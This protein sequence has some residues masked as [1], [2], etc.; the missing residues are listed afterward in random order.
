MHATHCSQGVAPVACVCPHGENAARRKVAES[1]ESR[2]GCGVAVLRR[3]YMY[4][5][6]GFCCPV[7]FCFFSTWGNLGVFAGTGEPAGDRVKQ[8][9]SRE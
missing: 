1:S 5:E 4:L 2:E 3:E 6:A 9:K 7:F 8:W